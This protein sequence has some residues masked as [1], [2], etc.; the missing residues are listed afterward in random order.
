[1]P[2]AQSGP[3][4]QPHP[5]C[6]QGD[7][8]PG[9]LRRRP[10]CQ[11][12]THHSLLPFFRQN[13]IPA[14]PGI[15]CLFYNY[16]KIKEKVK[17]FSV[18]FDRFPHFLHLVQYRRPCFAHFDESALTQRAKSIPK[19][20]FLIIFRLSGQFLFLAGECA[21]TF[22]E[23]YS[24][25]IFSPLVRREN[26]F[27]AAG[28]CISAPPCITHITISQQGIVTHHLPFRNH[29]CTIYCDSLTFYS[30]SVNP[31]AAKPLL[32]KSRRL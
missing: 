30:T 27:P 29:F 18:L 13:L 14:S 4:P 23:Y 24:L 19:L 32:D 5:I 31:I 25:Y 6:M 15:P 16:I 9:V 17:R 21:L 28:E 3:P 10:F 11:I 12:F 22:K 26:R 8:L 2:P 1:M 7:Y 20:K